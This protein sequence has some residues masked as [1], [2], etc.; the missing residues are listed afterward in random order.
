ML[1]EEYVR[2]YCPVAPPVGDNHFFLDKSGQ[3]LTGK[4]ASHLV[5]WIGEKCGVKDLTVN[6][7][8]AE[9]ETE[10]FVY[11][12]EEAA[13]VSRVGLNHSI[14]TAIEYYV[15]KTRRHAVGS[16]LRMNAMFEDCGERVWNE[17]AKA[18]YDPV[19]SVWKRLNYC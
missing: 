13:N 8:R 9:I 17:A 14:P 12:S 18:T 3:P 19:S 7:L 10:N 11:I 6:S 4:K 1:Y 5:R 16:S 15:S 2:K